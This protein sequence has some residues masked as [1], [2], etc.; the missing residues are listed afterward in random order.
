MVDVGP[1]A[2]PHNTG[3][4]KS[5]DLGRPAVLLVAPIKD[6]KN[7]SW[8]RLDHVN[9]VAYAKLENWGESLDRLLETNGT[10][11][12]A[13]PRPSSWVVGMEGGSRV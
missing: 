12:H 10:P 9:A 1:D 13:E 6:R 2:Q 4:S 11:H 3:H 5:L 7:R 8:P